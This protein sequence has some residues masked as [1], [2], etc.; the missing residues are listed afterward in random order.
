M[1]DEEQVEDRVGVVCEPEEAEEVFA[2]VVGKGIYEGCL[3]GE[4]DAS[5]A[6]DGLPAP[7][8]KLRQDVC[9]GGD[10]INDKR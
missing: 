2:S 4:Q 1:Q 6:C 10:E 3:K 8:V 9:A 5:D 7:V